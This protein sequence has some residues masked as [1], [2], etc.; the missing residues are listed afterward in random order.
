MH[1]SVAVSCLWLTKSL[2]WIILT[3][4]IW[5]ILTGKDWRIIEDDCFLIDFFSEYL[6]KQRSEVR[7][8]QLCKG[9]WWLDFLADN[10]YLLIFFLCYYKSIQLVNK[11][12][13]VFINYPKSIIW[14]ELVS[15]PNSVV[16]SMKENA[17]CLGSMVLGLYFVNVLRTRVDLQLCIWVWF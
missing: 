1:R 17:Y 9:D 2:F 3:F 8:F 11:S 4:I 13:L 12:Q 5:N 7:G 10:V 6:R 16:F 15:K 14:Q